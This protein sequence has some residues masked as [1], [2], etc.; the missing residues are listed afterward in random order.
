MN[1]QVTSQAHVMVV[2]DDPDVAEVVQLLLSCSGYQATVVGT[3]T[4]ALKTAAQTEFDLVVLDISLPDIDGWTVFS[5]LRGKKP[6]PVI[7]LTSRSLPTDLARARE[8]GI[9]HYLIKPR[10]ICKLTDTVR[11][12]LAA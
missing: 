4:A 1:E 10:G 8:L 2:E 5:Q 3:G 7:C 6:V 11:A 12:V 9:E